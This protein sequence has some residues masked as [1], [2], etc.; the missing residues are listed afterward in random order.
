MQLVVGLYNLDE[1]Q[2]SHSYAMCW[3]MVYGAILAGFK[4]TTK[5]TF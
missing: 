5:S 1:A 2:T 4:I 3:E